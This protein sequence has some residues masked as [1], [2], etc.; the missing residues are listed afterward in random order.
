MNDDREDREPSE[1]ERLPEPSTRADGDGGDGGDVDDT[2]DAGDG[3]DADSLPDLPELPADPSELPVDTDADA[4]LARLFDVAREA[5][6]DGRV[7]DALAAVESADR[8]ARADLPDGDRASVLR[9][10]CARVADLAEADPAVA[11]EYLDAMGRRL[12]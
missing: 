9:H 11:T 7:D 5:V 6:R 1:P 4:A 2:D 3:D 8:L 12:G 10:G